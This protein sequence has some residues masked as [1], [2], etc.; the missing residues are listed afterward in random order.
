LFVKIIYF[1][2]KI[3]W[4]KNPWFLAKIFGENIDFVCQKNLFLWQ[5]LFGLKL[6]VFRENISRKTQRFSAIFVRI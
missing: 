6:I 4:L 2:A 1:L 5:K 3:I